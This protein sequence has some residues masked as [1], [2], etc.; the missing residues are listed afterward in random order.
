MS[1][2][3]LVFISLAVLVTIVVMQNSEAVA[4][5]VLIWNIKVPKIILLPTFLILGYVTGYATAKFTRKP[6]K[7]TSEK[8]TDSSTP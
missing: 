8:S 2:K 7:Q 6:K 1:F 4:L 5:E 3:N